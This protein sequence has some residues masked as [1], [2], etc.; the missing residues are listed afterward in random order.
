[1]Q[2]AANLR[3]LPPPRHLARTRMIAVAL[4]V[5]STVRLLT[6]CRG[7]TPT[8]NSGSGGQGPPPATAKAA[9]QQ[10]DALNEL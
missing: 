3:R 7:E 1:M 8:G 4:L 9:D 6:A 2:D 5:M 10:P